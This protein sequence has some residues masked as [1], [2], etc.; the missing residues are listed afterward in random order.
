MQKLLLAVVA[1]GALSCLTSCRGQTS[2]EAPIVG[3]RNMYDQPRYDVQEESE[4]FPDHRT[5]RPTIHSA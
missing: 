4:F 3:I 1:F 2:H 5:M